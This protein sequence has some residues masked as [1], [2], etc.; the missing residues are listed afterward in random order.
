MQPGAV[1]A[2]EPPGTPVLVLWPGW[3]GQ[4][5]QLCRSLP[6]LN[7]YRGHWGET[8][9]TRTSTLS[10]LPGQASGPSHDL[11]PPGQSSTLG[12]CHSAHGP[13]TP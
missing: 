9:Q 7:S 5:E 6:S 3:L 11:A 2:E 4:W 10:C 12:K 1:L 8:S 13:V